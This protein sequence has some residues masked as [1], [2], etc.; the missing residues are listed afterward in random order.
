MFTYL[1]SFTKDELHQQDLTLQK[2]A[3][4]SCETSLK[5]LGDR[6]YGLAETDQRFI[7]FKKQRDA[8]IKRA[9]IIEEN[10]LK[11]TEVVSAY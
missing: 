11:L 6:M 4:H 8:V 3:L 7:N 1:F 2:F 10:I 5:F 9:L